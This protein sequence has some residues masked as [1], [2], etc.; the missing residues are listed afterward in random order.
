MKS[1][2]HELAL[3]EHLRKLDDCIKEGLVENQRN[4]GYNVSQASVELFSLYLHKLNLITAGKQWDHRMFKRSSIYEETP[5]FPNKKETLKLMEKIE[6]K[7][8]KLCYGKRK[9]EK[10]IKEMV[11]LLNKLRKIIGE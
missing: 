3:K 1:E 6:R 10:E 4:I 7:R 9:P 8:N 11:N 5:D 2:E